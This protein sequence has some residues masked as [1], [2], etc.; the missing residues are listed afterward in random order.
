MIEPEGTQAQNQRPRSRHAT[1]TTI[2]AATSM[3]RTNKVKESM[4]PSRTIVEYH[5]INLLCCATQ[6]DTFDQWDRRSTR[7]CCDAQSLTGVDPATALRI[8]FANA[9]IT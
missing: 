1:A 6:R 2:R 9:L 5:P 7:S 3:M 8:E 4:R